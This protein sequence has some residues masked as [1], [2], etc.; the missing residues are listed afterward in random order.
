MAGIRKKKAG[1]FL[2]S[3]VRQT[4]SKRGRVSGGSLPSQ[5]AAKWALQC[6]QMSQKS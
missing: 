1:H 4:R 3:S 2:L 6:H 5:G